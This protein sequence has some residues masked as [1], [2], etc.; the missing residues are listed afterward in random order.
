MGGDRRL[1][2]IV[3]A[4]G[5][6]K[7]L[8]P[9]TADRA[10]PAASAP[11]GSPGTPCVPGTPPRRAGWSQSRPNRRPDPPPRLSTLID[12]YIRQCRPC[13]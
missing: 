13:R 3:L 6:G 11:S 5:A 9:L 4:G 10:K 1:L 7:L 12:H 2:G 8:M